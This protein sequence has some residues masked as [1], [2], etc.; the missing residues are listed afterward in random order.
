MIPLTVVDN[1]YDD[2]FAI[3][4]FALRQDFF[5]TEHDA[6]PGLRTKMLLDIDKEFYNTFMI[7]VLNLFFNIPGDIIGC[8]FEVFFQSISERYRNTWVH[9][10]FGVSFTGIIYLNPDAPLSTGTAMYEEK[11]LN[12]RFD[13][14]EEKFNFYNGRLT[15]IELFDNA[16][17]KHNSKFIKTADISNVFNRLTIIP[18]DTWHNA[19]GFFGTDLNNSRLT[20]VFFVELDVQGNTRTP[21]S[22]LKGIN[23]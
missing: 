13:A 23:L 15:D 21:I 2:P 22:K 18:G 3:R 8:N 14:H 20:Q 5:R 12:T 6:W 17:E 4:E 10:D 16:T 11:Y 7:K 9:K 1:F 19:E